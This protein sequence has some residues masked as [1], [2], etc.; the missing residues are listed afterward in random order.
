MNTEVNE[1][2][3]IARKT[4]SDQ[5]KNTE[6]DFY[7]NWPEVWEYLHKDL[8]ATARGGGFSKTYTLSRYFGMIERT[9]I[10]PMEYRLIEVDKTLLIRTLT[11]K[12]FTVHYCHPAL[13]ISW[14]Q[15][16]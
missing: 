12:G 14:E 9:Q 16:K 1:L 5:R 15:T 8:L 6:K 7:S 3:E 4:V 10:T 13:R 11:D 2:T